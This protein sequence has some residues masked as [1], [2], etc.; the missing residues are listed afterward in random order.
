MSAEAEI[1][2]P[3]TRFLTRLVDGG[4]FRFCIEF[5]TGPNNPM[6]LSPD[7]KS[8]TESLRSLRF[9]RYNSSVVVAVNSPRMAVR[10]LVAGLATMKGRRFGPL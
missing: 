10:E 5:L 8:S 9:F 6:V 3:L 7:V 2:G 1:A 4:G